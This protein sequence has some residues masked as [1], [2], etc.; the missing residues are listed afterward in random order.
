MT[1]ALGG[2]FCAGLGPN[3]H[4]ESVN[5]FGEIYPPLRG[6]ASSESFRHRVTKSITL[7]HP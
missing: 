6:D 4:G 5:T 3:E 7:T 1:H 2:L